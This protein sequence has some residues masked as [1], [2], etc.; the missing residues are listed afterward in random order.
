[1]IMMITADF[2]ILTLEALNFFA[3]FMETKRFFFYFEI[4]PNVL[5]R[6]FRFI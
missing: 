1:M 4:I 5:V 6:S 2:H 3:K